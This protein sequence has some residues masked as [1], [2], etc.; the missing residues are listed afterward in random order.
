MSKKIGIMRNVRPG[1]WVAGWMLFLAVTVV[2]PLLWVGALLTFPA[3][4]EVWKTGSIQSISWNVQN[5]RSG[6]NYVTLEFSTDSGITWNQIAHDIPV[7]AGQ[8]AWTIP[9]RPAKHARIRITVWNLVMSEESVPSQSVVSTEQSN[10]FCITQDLQPPTAAH[11]PASAP[12]SPQT[13]NSEIMVVFNGQ[14]L[15][16]DVSPFLEGDRVML[17]FRSIFEAMGG[18][19]SWDEEQR[20]ATATRDGITIKLVIDSATAYVNQQA[21]QLDGAPEIVNG[22]IYV[23]LS[24]GSEALGAE[25]EWD[26]ASGTVSITWP[27]D[28]PPGS[29]GH[30]A[31]KDSRG[32][33]VIV[34]VAPKR[35]VVCN[36]YAADAICALGAADTIIGAPSDLVSIPLL[37][38]KISNAQSVGTLSSPNPDLIISL[39]PDIM[40]GSINQPQAFTSRLEKYGIPVVLLDCSRID[41][42]E[43]DLAVLGNILGRE[44]RAQQL[45]DFID[46]YRQLVEERLQVLPDQQRPKVYWEAADDYS[47]GGPGS[48]DGMLLSLLGADNIAGEKNAPVSIITP[49]WVVARNPDIIIKAADDNR[50]SSG[51]FATSDAMEK[52][53]DDIVNRPGWNHI[54]AVTKDRVYILSRSLVAGPQYIMGLIYAAKW[55]HPDLFQD[56]DPL[57]IHQ[58]MLSRFYNL[59]FNGTWA[60]PVI[61]SDREQTP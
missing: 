61:V 26:G 5:Y 17:P 59:D 1:A 50:V 9:N 30:I 42:M 4:G 48:P 21:V 27:S 6:D 44:Q 22:R 10:E 2:V 12:A 41:T 24:F 28:L 45:F 34:P 11:N 29:T 57:A 7:T 46:K 23:P 39:K 36:S 51:Y 56:T 8:Y 15:A 47:V 3:G 20:S 31:I 35:I 33:N 54:T 25:V 38:Q 32:R 13:I 14:P 37:S 43:S 52:Q 53:H 49:A 18:A 55:L 58:Q 60:Y 40:F 16:G 19:V